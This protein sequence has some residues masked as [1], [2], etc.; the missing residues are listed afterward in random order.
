MKN[1]D[2]WI[3][4]KKKVKGFYRDDEGRVRPITERTGEVYQWRRLTKGAVM[5][6]FEK[7]IAEPER[8]FLR[9]RDIIQLLQQEGYKIDGLI[10]VIRDLEAEGK[11]IHRDVGMTRLYTLPKEREIPP[12]RDIRREAMEKVDMDKIA[13]EHE[14]DW[15]QIVKWQ[16]GFPEDVDKFVKEYEDRVKHMYVLAKRYE[17]WRDT[18]ATSAAWRTI[19]LWLWYIDQAKQLKKKMSKVKRLGT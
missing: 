12:L 2:Y 4:S 3:K 10:E 7:H 8:E 19:A 13:R 18:L 15:K 16:L 6:I 14:D 5:R 17:E 1:L 11:I 9:L